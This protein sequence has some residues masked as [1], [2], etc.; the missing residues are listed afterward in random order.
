MN[1]ALSTVWIRRRYEIQ[2]EA[3]GFI[4]KHKDKTGVRMPKLEDLIGRRFGRVV[5][6][7]RVENYEGLAD[8][9]T[10]YVGDCDCGY[11]VVKCAR[12][13]KRTGNRT[14]CFHCGPSS[15]LQ[16]RKFRYGRNVNGFIDKNTVIY[17]EN[18][19]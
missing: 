9:R 4:E 17:K 16:K 3:S 5:I 18:H 11:T 14:R 15:P 8:S 2:K 13:F 12:D 10:Q 1:S 6:T 19:E 7:S